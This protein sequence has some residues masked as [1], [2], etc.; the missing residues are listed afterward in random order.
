MKSKENFPGLC[1]FPLGKRKQ[2]ERKEKKKKEIKGKEKERRGE[3]PFFKPVCCL[4][5]CLFSPGISSISYK[6]NHNNK[7]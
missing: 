5:V 3:G 2:K 1:L 6:N 7:K 4:S